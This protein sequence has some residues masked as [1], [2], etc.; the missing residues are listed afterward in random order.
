MF[1][2]LQAEAADL[3]KRS[4][5]GS[6]IVPIQSLEPYPLRVLCPILAVVQ[7]DNDAFLAS[8][9]DANAN[10][11]GDTELDAIDMLKHVIAQNFCLYSREEEKLGDDLRKRL[12]VMRDFLKAV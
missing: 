11:S 3:K 8:W 12:A 10:A 2:S 1:E 5:D 6:V 9:F 7:F 4:T